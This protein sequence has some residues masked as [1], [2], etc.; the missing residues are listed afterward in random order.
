MS[1][2]PLAHTRRRIGLAVALGLTL[3]AVWWVNQPAATTGPVEP[4]VVSTQRA[5]TAKALP[6]LRD[7]S[8]WTLVWP[9]RSASAPSIIDI[10][11]ITPPPLPP[12][13][14]VPTAPGVAAPVFALRYIGR[15][16]E[17]DNH[18]VFLADAADT[19]VTVLKPGQ[20]LG[21]D[22]TLTA[23]NAAQLVFIHT[24]GQQHTLQIDPPL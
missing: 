18:Q 23:M 10:F 11:S 14:P 8:T 4:R 6:A 5:T 15:L 24:S 16:D 20:A 17:G 2:Q 19:V 3:M 7:R 21:G 13:R 9:D 1:T 22:W 12:S